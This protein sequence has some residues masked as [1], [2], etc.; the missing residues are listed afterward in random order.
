MIETNRRKEKP[1]SDER[2]EQSIPG[3]TPKE[4]LC[5]IEYSHLMLKPEAIEVIGGN[6][7]FEQAFTQML[8]S[9]FGALELDVVCDVEGCLP[10]EVVNEN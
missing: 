10:A 5:G 8:L 2:T 1:C 3:L 7:E 4:I 9:A 6:P